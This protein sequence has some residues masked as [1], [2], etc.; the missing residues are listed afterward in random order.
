MFECP[1]LLKLMLPILKADF[2]LCQTHSYLSDSPLACP[3]VAFGGSHE[4]I[5]REELEAWKEQTTGR[6]LVHVL[7]GDHFFI[8]DQQETLVRI[9]V[10]RV[11][12]ILA[13]K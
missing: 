7:P 2:E 13:R 6:L 3:I 1:E 9:I 5:T 12:E 4:K 11:M 8:R 10:S